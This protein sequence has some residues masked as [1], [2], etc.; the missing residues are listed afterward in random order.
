MKLLSLKSKEVADKEEKDQSTWSLNKTIY[1]GNSSNEVRY[2]ISWQ[3]GYT[4]YKC[5]LFAGWRSAV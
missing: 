5:R 4:L 1:L 2:Q 3:K